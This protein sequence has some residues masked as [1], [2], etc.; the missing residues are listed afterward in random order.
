MWHSGK[1]R[2]HPRTS[3]S[4]S[5]VRE[6]PR[7]GIST[8]LT[9][10]SFLSQPGCHLSWIVSSEAAPGLRLILCIVHASF[11]C[12]CLFTVSLS[13]VRSRR[14]GTISISV[15]FIATSGLCQYLWN[16]L[17]EPDQDSVDLNLTESLGDTHQEATTGTALS[18]F[19]HASS[20]L[21]PPE[22]QT[23]TSPFSPLDTLFFPISTCLT[24][25][26]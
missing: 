19:S 2:A 23:K 4:G 6:G 22:K 25:Q 1:E 12:F 8:W 3:M 20:H 16:K 24:E 11:V 15:A 14:T 21:L 13:Q 18:S 7:P 5:R 10:R 17:G 26:S 9:P